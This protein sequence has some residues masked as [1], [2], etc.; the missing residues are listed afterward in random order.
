MVLDDLYIAEAVVNGAPATVTGFRMHHN[1]ISIQAYD[2]LGIC[3][4]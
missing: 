4:D 3:P 1:W 2:D